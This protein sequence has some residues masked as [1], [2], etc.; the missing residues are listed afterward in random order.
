MTSETF[1][2]GREG[3][4]VAQPG[5]K[6][7]DP[8]PARGWVSA[9]KEFYDE[10]SC[11]G[12]ISHGILVL[13][14]MRSRQSTASD[15]CLQPAKGQCRTNRHPPCDARGTRQTGFEEHRSRDPLSEST[16]AGRGELK[17]TLGFNHFDEF[18]GTMLDGDD[19]RRDPSVGPENPCHPSRSS[20]PSQSL[21]RFPA[22]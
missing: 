7:S 19:H 13:Q 6:R 16:P 15:S 18:E 1:I 22:R 20:V 2:T 4:S 11:C 14:R 5:P 17:L 12:D 3:S 9:S 8:G 10:S 21:R